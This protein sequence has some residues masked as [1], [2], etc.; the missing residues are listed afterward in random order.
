[1]SQPAGQNDVLNVT[2]RQKCETERLEKFRFNVSTS[3][4]TFSYRLLEVGTRRLPPRI[5]RLGVVEL[6]ES[7]ESGGDADA[8]ASEEES[9]ASEAS[10]A[11]G[12]LELGYR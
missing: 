2:G 4:S 7:Y 12:L 9:S 6:V 1:M 3:V 8:E 5:S 11:A 10:H